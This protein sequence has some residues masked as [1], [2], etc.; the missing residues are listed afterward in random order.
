MLNQIL[1]YFRPY[2]GIGQNFPLMRIYELPPWEPDCSMLIDWIPVVALALGF[3][4]SLALMIIVLEVRR[5]P[6]PGHY[7]E[8]H[9]NDPPTEEGSA[10]DPPDE[11]GAKS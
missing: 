3:F 10:K 4:Y 5:A 9:P 2:V 11:N 6:G 8:D 7:P 1:G